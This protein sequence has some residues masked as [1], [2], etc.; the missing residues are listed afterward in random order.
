[1]RPGLATAEI[2]L[3]ILSTKSCSTARACRGSACRLAPISLA[4]RCNIFATSI[5]YCS[6]LFF[7]LY[8]LR[9]AFQFH[10]EKLEASFSYLYLS[11]SI[12]YAVVKE[13]AQDRSCAGK[14]VWFLP[15]CSATEKGLLC[16]YENSSEFPQINK[17]LFQYISLSVEWA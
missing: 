17:R 1:M 14:S 4:Q 3:V 2:V 12:L 8:L 9:L 6:L 16:V 7:F 10:I 15:L 11:T 13:H 5:L